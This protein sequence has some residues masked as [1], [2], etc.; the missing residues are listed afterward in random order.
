MFYFAISHV[1]SKLQLQKLQ[2]SDGQSLQQWIEAHAAD[3]P[4]IIMHHAHSPGPAAP[5]ANI[6][7]KSS[8]GNAQKRILTEET[9]DVPELT[10]FEISQYQVR[11][12]LCF[13]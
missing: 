8:A 13:R 12:P 4:V 11:S 3:R 6:N 1:C 7:K 5:T 9:G 10:E 2:T